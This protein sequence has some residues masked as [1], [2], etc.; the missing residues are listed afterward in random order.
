MDISNKTLAWLL[1][2][3]I[4]VSILGTFTALNRIQRLG[5]TGAATENATGQTQLQVQTSASIRFAD[6]TVDFGSWQ[7][8]ASAYTNCTIETETPSASSGCIGG[9]APNDY[10]VI[11]ND[12]NVNFTSVNLKSN[13]TAAQFIGG[14]SSIVKF[15]W[16]IA[17]NE[18]P[19]PSCSALYQDD[20]WHDVDTSAS[21]VKICDDFNF[22]N[23]KDSLRVYFRIVIPYDAPQGVKTA[24]IK[25]IG[26]Y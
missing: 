5:I 11:E 4:I 19:G 6:D 22:L 24:Q 12:G 23:D 14:N 13:A 1:V 7:V 15:Q 3:A 25:V 21:G 16:K 8:N 26:N 2:G 18:T 9:S 10:L 20:D 17:D